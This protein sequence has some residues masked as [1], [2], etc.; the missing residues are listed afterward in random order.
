MNT[1]FIGQHHIHF[2]SIDST[3]LFAVG[4]INDSS[5]FEGTLIT[6]TEQLSGKGQ[7]GNTWDSEA[8]K[9]LTLSI[10]LKPLFLAPQRQFQLNKMVSLAVLDFIIS[11]FNAN[12][13]VKWPNDVYINDKKA[14]GV[15]IQNFLR[16]DKITHSVIGIGININQMDFSGELEHATSLKAVSG[17]DFDLNECLNE[18]CECMEARYFQLKSGS[19]RINIDYLKNLYQLEEFKNYFI[20]DILVSARIKGVSGPGKLILENMDKDIIECDLKEIRFTR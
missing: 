16:Q 11:K 3:N 7:R 4:L 6:A 5:A 8:G 15:L 13:S 17:G 10:I 9:N 14:G 12:I 1:L 19:E 2:P 20:G 18:L